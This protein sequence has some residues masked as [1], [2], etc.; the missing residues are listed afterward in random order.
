MT[1]LKRIAVFCGSRL[2][3]NPIIAQEL[4]HLGEIL[5][6]HGMDVVYGG[7]N[8]GLMKVVADSALEAGISVFGV[9]PKNLMGKELVHEGLTKLYEVKDMAERKD[10]MEALSDAF[11]ILPGGFGTMD[12]LFEML[13]WQQIGFKKKPIALWNVAGFYNSLI[14]HFDRMYEEGY[15]Q[16]PTREAL[17]IEEDLER[18]IERI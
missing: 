12:E 3:K 8:S 10:K 14:S 4:S 1:D 11:L 16:I 6:G 13:T 2:G 7:A 5:R 18:L 9:F 15:T 17:I